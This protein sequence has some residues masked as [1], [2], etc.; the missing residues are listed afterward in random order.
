MQ[1]LIIFFE[2]MQTLEITH[3]KKLT[4]YFALSSKHNIVIS[5][6]LW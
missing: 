5:D 1:Q 6:M 2:I 4:Y 3:F